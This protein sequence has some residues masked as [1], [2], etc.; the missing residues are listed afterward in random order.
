MVQQHAR[1]VSR[2]VVDFGNVQENRK[3]A[4][5]RISFTHIPDLEVERD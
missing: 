3:T 1:D 2:K 5:M 4:S